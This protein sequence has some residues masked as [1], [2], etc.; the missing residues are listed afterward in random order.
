MNARWYAHFFDDAAFF[1]WAIVGLRIEEIERDYGL[2]TVSASTTTNLVKELTAG[3]LV[4]VDGCLTRLGGKS[5]TFEMRLLNYDTKEVHATYLLTEVFFDPRSR[6][7]AMIPGAVR[8]AMAD[9]V[10]TDDEG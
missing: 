10:V 1:L 6:S 3:T 5:M 4:E 2:H 9:F 8:D 7:S